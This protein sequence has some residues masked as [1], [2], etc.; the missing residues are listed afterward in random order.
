MATAGPDRQRMLRRR[1][2]HERQA[3]VL[4][5]LVAALAV[6]FFGALAVYTDTLAMP[7]LD[8][9]F[10][11][12]E[13]VA[14]EVVAAPP[15][16]PEGT[17]PLAHPAIGV[18]VYNAAGIS[19]LAG[20]TAAALAERGYMVLTSDNYPDTIGSTAH[21]VFGQLGIA[22]A[23]TLA[24]QVDNPVLLLDA[25][26]DGSVDLVLGEAFDRLVDPTLILLDPLVP[27]V[28]LPGCVPLET[29][30][31]ALPPA[32]IPEPSDPATDEVPVDGGENFE[33]EVPA[34]GDPLPPVE[35]EPL[36]P[37]EG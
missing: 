24:A 21:I 7:F 16:V 28:P 19:G 20:S 30:V 1:R 22:G 25:R 9:E 8:R 4:G 37:A 13:P 2:M 34:E 10:T 5:C 12:P 11:T 26:A 17:L 3:V 18:N 6:G 35:G 32:T 14:G 27:F 33:G 31:A 36:P 23:Y 29:A 15:C